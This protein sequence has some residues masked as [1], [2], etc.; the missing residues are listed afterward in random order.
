MPLHTRITDMAH[1]RGMNAAEISR[2]AGLFRSNIS[3][4]DAGKRSVSL[5]LLERVAESLGLSPIDLLDQ[6]LDLTP[7]FKRQKIMKRLLD[8]DRAG[9]DGLEKGWV[10]NVMLAWQNHY[11]KTLPQS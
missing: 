8:L 3:S 11:R 1:E 4:M 6:K 10:H 5:Q 2:R 7:V 9:A